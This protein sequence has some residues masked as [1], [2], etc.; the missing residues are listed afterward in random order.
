MEID[1]RIAANVSTEGYVVPELLSS[2]REIDLV[3]LDDGREV[4]RRSVRMQPVNSEKVWQLV[5]FGRVPLSKTSTGFAKL[6][7]S[8]VIDGGNPVDVRVDY[9]SVQPVVSSAALRRQPLQAGSAQLGALPPMDS[10]SLDGSAGE[11]G[12]TWASTGWERYPAADVYRSTGVGSALL[13]TVQLPAGVRARVSS[14][15]GED[16]KVV[17]AQATGGTGSVELARAGGVSSINVTTPAGVLRQWVVD[18][19]LENGVEYDIEIVLDDS[20]RWTVGVAA[21][22]STIRP[23]G[24]GTLLAT[25]TGGTWRGGVVSTS[26]STEIRAR[27]VLI[28]TASDGSTQLAWSYQAGAT[29]AVGE[30][31][32]LLPGAPAKISVRAGGDHDD[33]LPGH[34]PSSVSVSIVPLYLHVPG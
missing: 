1:A 21:A 3:L 28:Q 27:S 4:A 14:P 18:L 19:D 15:N 17:L 32:R 6:Q 33:A 34:A 26:A 11:L 9:L 7:L 20:G 16:F 24:S 8:A 31:P 13:G 29:L 10:S 12:G 23:L 25:W 5:R 2:V 30:L 22:G